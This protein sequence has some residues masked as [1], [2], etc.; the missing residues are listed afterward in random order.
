MIDPDGDNVRCRWAV[1]EECRAICN[2]VPVASIEEVM[3]ILF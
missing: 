3:A 1:G 2:N